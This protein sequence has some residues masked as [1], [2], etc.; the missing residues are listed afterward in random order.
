MNKFQIEVDYQTGNTFGSSDETRIIEDL[1]FDDIESAKEALQIL[2]K[3]HD[4]TQRQI[5]YL[6]KEEQ[7]EH[8]V[9]L[10]LQPWAVKS[11]Y[12][13]SYEFEFKVRTSKDSTEWVQ[14][15][16]FWH[17]YFERL[18][19]ARIVDAGRDELSVSFR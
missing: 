15:Y 5:A 19:E 12:S 8:L 13:P 18:H 1:F 3:H 14:V 6:P 17:G 11:S 4:M 7:Q 16:A 9:T 10:S 2:K